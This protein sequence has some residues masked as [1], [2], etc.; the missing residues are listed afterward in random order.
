MRRKWWI[1][2]ASLGLVPVPPAGAD[3][4]GRLFFTPEQRALLDLARRTHTAAASGER[5][6]GVALNGIVSRSDGRQ[7]VWVN[8]RPVT[9]AEVRLRDP[10]TAVILLPGGGPVRLRVGQTL[11]P[12]SG[13]VEEGR[14]TT[15][16]AP[17]QPPADGEASRPAKGA[18]GAARDGEEADESSR[19]PVRP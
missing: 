1:I 15:P 17:A 12:V 14:R 3:E 2:L 19:S 9:A 10:A 16:G 8:G 5:T 6:D 7:T 11:D 4:L 13:R 18:A